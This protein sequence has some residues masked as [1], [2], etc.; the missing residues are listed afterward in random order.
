MHYKKGLFGFSADPITLGHLDVIQKSL[1]ECET[2]VVLVA[3]NPKKSADYIFS[4]EERAALTRSA[5]ETLPQDLQAR[6]TVVTTPGLLI[7]VYLTENCD[8]IVRGIRN[9]HDELFEN[10]QRSLYTVM[11]PALSDRFLYIE[12]DPAYSAISSSWVKEL[13]RSH[14]DVSALVPLT[15]KAALEFR[16]HEQK[17]IGIT[18]PIAS[19]K[20]TVAGAL[21]SHL[22]SLL[23]DAHHI[24]IDDLVRTL[25]AEDSLGAQ[26]V[27]DQI[28]ACFGNTVA[29]R[30]GAAINTAALTRAVFAG[31]AETIAANRLFLEQLTAP[32]IMRLFRERIHG[33]SGILFVEWS[34]YLS[35][36]LLPLLNNTII[37]IDTPYETRVQYA[38]KRG[39]DPTL[40]ETI[41]QTQKSAAEMHEY[42]ANSC[43]NDAY[44]RCIVMSSET[45]KDEI[46]DQILAIQSLPFPQG[47]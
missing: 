3:N 17:F 19:G 6:I 15:V 10:E 14:V 5:I 4:L 27:R 2:L 31:N 22:E 7:D 29:D 41:N 45:P 16:L 24:A 40:F 21:V 8:A 12:A 36:N 28:I 20:T 1:V 38:T 34:D 23:I 46:I 11:L 26:A 25:Y 37:L 30:G 18:G 33:L 32:H 42:I 39:I 44:G 9:S 43:A 47:S 13:V 35:Q